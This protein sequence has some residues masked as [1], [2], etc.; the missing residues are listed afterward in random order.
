MLGCTHTA[1][2]AMKEAKIRVMEQKKLREG[3]HSGRLLGEYSVDRIVDEHMCRSNS[4]LEFQVVWRGY[5]HE[6]DWTWEPLEAVD[7]TEAYVKWLLARPEAG[8]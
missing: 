4:E 7:D 5:E 1:L 6:D 2:Q 8:A 3:R